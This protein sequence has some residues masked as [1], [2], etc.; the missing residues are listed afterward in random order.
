MHANTATNNSAPIFKSTPLNPSSINSL[1]LSGIRVQLDHGVTTTK[2]FK[3]NLGGCRVRAFPEGR[4][5]EFVRSEAVHGHCEEFVDGGQ[6][7][8]VIEEGDPEEGA[9]VRVSYNKAFINQYFEASSNASTLASPVTSLFEPP[10]AISELYLAQDTLEA[11]VLTEVELKRI[12]EKL[13]QRK[14]F[15]CIDISQSPILT[16]ECS[17]GHTFT[18]NCLEEVTCHNCEVIKAKCSQYAKHHNGNSVIDLF[19]Q[20]TQ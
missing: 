19:R 8:E 17:G 11:T 7:E 10:E 1:R 9:P 16:F 6:P 13:K 5:E 14:G 2:K 20:D 3:P 15:E 4:K 12:I 18:A